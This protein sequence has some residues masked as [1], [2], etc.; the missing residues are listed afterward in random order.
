M[1]R[2][3][4]KARR[5]NSHRGICHSAWLSSTEENRYREVCRKYGFESFVD[6]VRFAL[7]EISSRLP[8]S[9][10][11]VRIELDP[12][13]DAKRVALAQQSLS[14]KAYALQEAWRG[15]WN[16][17]RRSE[18]RQQVA[19]LLDA[20]YEWSVVLEKFEQRR[21]VLETGLRHPRHRFKDSKSPSAIS[22]SVTNEE[23]TG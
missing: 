8:E 22:S 13:K 2:T 4:T 6:F 7:R 20:A 15:E 19:E 18:L 12:E 17:E 23:P 5:K 9:Q 10:G 11:K 1:A 21:Y 14:E 16:P 3:A